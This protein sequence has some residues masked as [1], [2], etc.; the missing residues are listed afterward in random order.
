MPDFLKDSQVSLK[1]RRG[2]STD[3]LPL[4][5]PLGINTVLFI[6][7]ALEILEKR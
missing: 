3:N 2:E 6:T 5:A 4:Q 1:Q 7:A